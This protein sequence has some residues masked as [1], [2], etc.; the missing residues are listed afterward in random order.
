MNTLP[1][2]VTTT[3]EEISEFL[4]ANPHL[5]RKIITAQARHERRVKRIQHRKAMQEQEDGNYQHG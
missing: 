1:I 3:N 5:S 4:E 2:S